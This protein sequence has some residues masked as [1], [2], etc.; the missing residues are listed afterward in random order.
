MLVDETV[1]T[2]LLACPACGAAL[3]PLPD[4][5]WRCTATDCEN[6][7]TPFPRVGTKSILVNFAASVLDK[8]S[9]T[10]SGGASVIS[11]H[12]SWLA[13]LFAAINGHNPVT[14]HF[15]R[16]M[17]D[18]CRA[19]A[20]ED[21]RRARVLVVGGAKIGSGAD[22]LYQTADV[23][24][25]TFDIYD[26]PHVT[27]LADAHAM[28][29]RDGSVDGVWIQAVLEHVVDPVQVVREIERVLRPRGLVFADTP[30]LWPVHE[31]AYDFTRWTLSGHR[32]LFRGFDVLAAGSSSGPG[33]VSLLAL[34]YLAASLFR[35]PKIG[36]ILTLPLLWLRLLDRFCDDQKGLDAAAGIFFYGRKT[37]AALTAKELIAFY[38]EQ[39]GLQKAARR[40]SAA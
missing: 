13:R 7:A 4:G 28:P 15:S 22:F 25:I 8:E 32:W 5:S 2:S 12:P 29:F 33:T 37:D 36:Q 3:E 30:F 10:T 18:A 34:R 31:K 19:L 6:R 17:V 9:M 40:R 39:V 14:P 27:V 35:S 26:T 21:G 23:D 16:E 1:L 38:G 20:A 11:R 24:L